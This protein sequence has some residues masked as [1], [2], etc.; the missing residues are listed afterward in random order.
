MTTSPNETDALLARITILETHVAHQDEVIEELS[1]VLAQQCENINEVAS[2]LHQI[3]LK[4][5]KLDEDFG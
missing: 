1:T 2:K 3:Q 5:E 4:I